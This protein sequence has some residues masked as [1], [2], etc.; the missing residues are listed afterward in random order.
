MFVIGRSVKDYSECKPEVLADFGRLSV[1]MS[2]QDAGID[3]R[4]EDVVH[5]VKPSAITLAHIRSLTDS[6]IARLGGKQV[7]A[8]SDMST[9][10]LIHQAESGAVMVDDEYIET[11]C[12]AVLD[13]L[14][15]RFDQETTAVMAHFR[16]T[17][18]M[19][20]EAGWTV[21]SSQAH[22][23][24]VDLSE[25]HSLV[26]VNAGYSGAKHTQRRE[27][28]VNLNKH[29][30]KTVVHHITVESGLS[31]EVYKSVSK[32]LDFNLQ[33]FRAWK[34]SERAD[35]AKEDH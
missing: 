23:E 20:R 15:A 16:A 31:P 35:V 27:R 4:V 17:Q 32:K 13:Y 12:H 30:D 14:W 6:G 5:I 29:R 26:I 25:Y 2:Q 8:E 3:V 11:G 19:L 10:V 1:T 22:A 18:R 34:R 7:V 24:G 33:S 28:L 9:R 21:F